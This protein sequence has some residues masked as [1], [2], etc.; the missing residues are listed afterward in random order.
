MQ[1]VN[2]APRSALIDAGPFARLLRAVL[3]APEIE[4][5]QIIM[6]A[7]RIRVDSVTRIVFGGLITVVL[8][9][10]TL[11]A[12]KESAPGA[13][14][15]FV[16]FIC[17]SP[18]MFVSGSR[19]LK[20]A[21]EHFSLRHWRFVFMALYGANGILW[22]LLLHFA[23]AEESAATQAFVLLVVIAHLTTYL[24]NLGSHL[25]SFLTTT[26][27][28]AV[29]SEILLLGKPSDI[30][31]LIGVVFPMFSI[32]L[33][34]LG[35]DA[36]RRLGESLRRS[37]ELKSM[38]DDLEV[39]R[40]EAVA[41]GQARYSFFASMSHELRT[42]LNAIIGFA[43]M[44]MH[45]IHGELGSPRYSGYV[46]DIH[47]S[48]H[49]LLQLVN[50]LLDLSSAHHQRME[51]R[52]AEVELDALLEEAGAALLPAAREKNVRFV[53][54]VPAGTRV[55]LD[56]IRMLQVLVNIGSNAINFSDPG[57]HVSVTAEERP[58][59]TLL[60]S[61]QD[62]GVGISPEDLSRIIDPMAN[63]KPRELTRQQGNGTGLGL[64]VSREMV[65]LH[66]GS[67]RIE[68]EVGLGTTVTLSLPGAL[69]DRQQARTD[70]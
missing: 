14:T 7:R 33:L 45:R 35:Y 28:V 50:D 16:L 68:S 56:P 48:G 47:K 64:A 26:V 3:D 65:E 24:V 12:T 51:I 37:M 63:A 1:P 52:R 39:A 59:N 61:V 2:P 19:L 49:H 23:W 67:L 6:M 9:L 8:S 18:V 44:M 17:L 40:A 25:L 58:G 31:T 42:P 15:W 20:R 57:G 60:I 55:S 43:E 30:A 13:I 29:F 27:T 53:L 11:L 38:A 41:A 4:R 5:E 70:D 34:V 32:Y 22:S 66:G 69:L 10:P 46:Q 36:N 54:N 62:E 21:P